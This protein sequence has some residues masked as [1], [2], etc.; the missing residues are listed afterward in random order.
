MP[1]PPLEFLHSL[2]SEDE[3]V[4]AVHA[5]LGAWLPA[6][7]ARL[8]MPVRSSEIR[9]GE[10]VSRMAVGIAQMRLDPRVSQDVRDVLEQLHPFF[11]EAAA[12]VCHIHTFPPRVESRQETMRKLFG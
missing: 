8:P 5:Y 10:D 3:L 7:L 11:S 2:K 6:S 12:R 4:E 9:A 1:H